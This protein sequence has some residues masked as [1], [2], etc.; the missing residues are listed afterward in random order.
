MPLQIVDATEDDISEMMRMDR[1]AY[2]GSM[3]EKLFFPHGWSDEVLELQGEGILKPAREDPTVRNIKVIDTDHNDEVIAFARW[4][5]YFGDNAR[6][7]KTNVHSKG[8][9]IGADPAALAMWNT[10][11]RKKRIET[12]GLTPHCC[13]DSMLWV[14]VDWLTWN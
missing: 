6:Y 11:V 10:T 1:E 14:E 5:F 7:I 12:I 13:E 4:N 3:A 2:T 8:G 9:I